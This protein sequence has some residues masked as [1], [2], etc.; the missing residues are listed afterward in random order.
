MRN[1]GIGRLFPG[2][3]RLALGL[4]AVLLGGCGERGRL[5]FDPGPGGGDGAGPI[6]VIEEPAADTTV[7]PGTTLAIQARV[8][9]PDLIDSIYL[10]VRNPGPVFE[11]YVVTGDPRLEV[12][13]SLPITFESAPGDTFEVWV[14][15]TDG[16]GA[17]GDTAV[18][19]VALR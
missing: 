2:P 12:A 14:Y 4:G 17:R 1:T 19:R 3:G 9:D 6:A 18:R 8:R 16:T 13:F 10:E 7:D 5:T 11:P 15:A